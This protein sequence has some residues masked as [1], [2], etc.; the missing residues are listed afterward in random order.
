MTLEELTGCGPEIAEKFFSEEESRKMLDA[1]RTVLE[2]EEKKGI[3]L[4]AVNREG[5]EGCFFQLAYPW[6]SADGTL[7]GV[8]VLGQDIT[9]L[10]QAQEKAQ[11]LQKKLARSEKMEALGRLAAGVAHDLSNVLSPVVGY[12]EVLLSGIDRDDPLYRPLV[13]IRD[14]GEKAAA[15]TNDLLTI[16][17]RGVVPKEIVNLNRIAE[18][19]INS[20]E[21]RELELLYPGIEVT[22]EFDPGLKNTE[23]ASVHL[24]KTIM[25]LV[26]NAADAMPKGGEIVIRT[27]NRLLDTPYKGFHTI[28]PGEYTV[29]TVKDSGIGISSEEITKVFDP[30]YSKKVKERTG[31]GL[32][33]TVVHGTMEDHNGYIDI[34]SRENEGTVFDLY[35]PV[36][37]RPIH[38]KAVASIEQYTGTGTVLVVDEIKE[39]REIAHLMLTRL[40]YT[41]IAAGSG[42]EAVDMARDQKPDLMLVEMIM[43][44]GIDGMETFKQIAEILPKVKA[45]L[46][47]RYTEIEILTQA[48]EMGITRFLKKPYTMQTLGMTVKEEMEN[49]A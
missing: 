36:T 48:E 40:G 14:A 22:G 17:R 32:G 28:P 41:V 9:E 19:Y 11:K 29:L 43:E 30:F 37:D 16:A 35:L 24:T 27:E 26:S 42:E 10:K 7:G 13:S 21:Y 49:R 15:M 20:P 6:Y 39:Q 12:P 46:T 44:S 5:R 2:K 3:E 23:G 34:A 31:T 33:L 25:N 47:G 38:S 18:E 8:E 4:K 45:V 1:L